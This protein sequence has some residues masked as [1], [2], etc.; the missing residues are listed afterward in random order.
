MPLINHSPEF[1]AK[2]ARRLASE[3][4]A[5]QREKEIQQQKEDLIESIAPSKQYTFEDLRKHLEESYL[6]DKSPYMRLTLSEQQ[7]IHDLIRKIRLNP[8][9]CKQLTGQSSIELMD[10]FQAI[11]DKLGLNQ[12]LNAIPLQPVS[13]GGRPRKSVN[14]LHGEQKPVKPTLVNGIPIIPTPNS[15]VAKGLRENEK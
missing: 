11:Q 15:M 12:A 9:I 1:L 2:Q 10:K 13:K 6:K 7:F 4:R 3:Q 8:E 14:T 5:I